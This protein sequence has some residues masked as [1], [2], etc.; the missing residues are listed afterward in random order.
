[1]NELIIGF[2][3]YLPI[4]V[5]VAKLFNYL[6]RHIKKIEMSDINIYHNIFLGL[7]WPISL[8]IVIFSWI[9]YYCFLKPIKFLFFR[10]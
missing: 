7:L 3:L 5:S 2:V 8:T 4:A 1:M 10:N 6:E 9:C